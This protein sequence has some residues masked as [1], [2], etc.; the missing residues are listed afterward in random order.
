M[1]F[2]F[3]TIPDRLSYFRRN[4]YLKFSVPPL[5]KWLFL[6]FK[7]YLAIFQLN[8]SFKPSKRAGVCYR[9][10]IAESHA[11]GCS[12]ARELQNPT[13]WRDPSPR[14]RG[15]PRAGVFYRSGIAESHALERSTAQESHNPTRRKGPPL[16]NRGIP[17]AGVVYR[18]EIVESHAQ[19]PSTAQELG[20]LTRGNR[21]PLG[22]SEIS[23]AVI[24][25]RTRT[26]IKSL[27]EYNPSCT[28]RCRKIR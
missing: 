13:R 6:A 21:P 7:V 23:R 5:I 10:G 17:R 24:A 15:I 2:Y 1:Y 8:Q 12:I 27:I 3:S 11:R 20:N 18:S 16:R 25:H 4:L 9:S 28:K 19:E 22:N 26:A 14:N